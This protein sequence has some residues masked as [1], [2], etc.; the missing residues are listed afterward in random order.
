MRRQYS[1][2]HHSWIDTEAAT[3]AKTVANAPGCF[4][5][6]I[7]SVWLLVVVGVAGSGMMGRVVVAIDVVVVS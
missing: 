4:V 7:V 5:V 3:V 2:L 6:V 1:Q